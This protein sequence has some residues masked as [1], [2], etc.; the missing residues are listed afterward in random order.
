MSTRRE[1]T[2]A[3]T[4]AEIKATALRLMREQGS[5][6][7]RFADIAR[8]MSMTAPALYRYFSGRDE[9]LTALLEDAFTSLAEALEKALADEGSADPT[10]AFL[11]VCR[12]Y[13]S[14]GREDPTRYALV[15]GVPVPGYDA[16]EQGPHSEAADRAFG[17][18]A[19]TAANALAA[20][21][22]VRPL[23]PPVTGPL[24]EVLCQ[25]AKS[26]SLP[27]QAMQAMLHSW[28]G[29]HGFV[30]LEAFGH[31]HWLPAEASDDLYEGLIRGMATYIGL[32]AGDPDRPAG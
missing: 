23:G 26:A 30:T 7:V 19:A 25:P 9:L 8:E 28:A 14:W 3:A 12:S 18:M 5:S 16:P 24:A 6:D 17:C 27:P 13:R 32:P 31:L 4:V 11:A 1:I 20:G 10:T 29:I 22:D 2:R 21:L 15:F